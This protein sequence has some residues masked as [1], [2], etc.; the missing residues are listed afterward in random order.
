MIFIKQVND[1][2]FW[3]CYTGRNGT[4][5]ATEEKLEFSRSNWAITGLFG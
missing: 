4:V 1:S 3:C 2:R 5:S